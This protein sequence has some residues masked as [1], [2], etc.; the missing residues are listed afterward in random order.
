MKYI[1]KITSDE[2]NEA[3]K[4][5]YDVLPKEEFWEVRGLEATDNDLCYSSIDNSVYFHFRNSDSNFG[6]FAIQKKVENIRAVYEFL[7]TLVEEGIG[8][9]KFCS[10]KGRYN[11]ILKHFIAIFQDKEVTEK[12]LEKKDHYIWYIGHPENIKRFEKRINR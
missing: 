6:Y 2:L 5:A 3:L 4:K 7:Y 11:I 12:Q 1:K 10:S 9:I 8:Y